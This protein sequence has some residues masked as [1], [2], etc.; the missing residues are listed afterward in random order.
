MSRPTIPKVKKQ[1]V[2]RE[3]KLELKELNPQLLDYLT[4]E[5]IG[6]GSYGQC[7]PTHYREIYVVVKMI[8]SDTTEDKLR[9]KRELIH[10]AE[11]ITALDDH[12][13]YP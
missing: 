12:K 3:I 4:Q 8:Y 9:A 2:V 13:D 1:L 11:V 10:D 7:Y 5:S 6:S